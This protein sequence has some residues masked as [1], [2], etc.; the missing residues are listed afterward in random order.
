MP[1]DAFRAQLVEAWDDAFDE[2]FIQNRYPTEATKAHGMGY[3]DDSLGY[4]TLEGTDW[5]F[6]PKLKKQGEGDAWQHSPIGGELYPS[7]QECA[8][9]EPLRCPDMEAGRDYKAL[10]SIQKAHARGSSITM[11]S[12]SV[13]AATSDARQGRERPPWATRCRPPAR[14]RRTTR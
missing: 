6:I 4:A 2:T 11:L 10:E 3:Y 7:F 9:S 1:S 14:R 5:H 13:T 12:R 8:F